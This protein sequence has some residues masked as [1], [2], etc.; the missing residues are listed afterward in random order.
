M[1]SELTQQQFNNL[2][3]KIQQNQIDPIGL[4]LYARAH[5][6]RQYKKVEEHWG[7]T[8]SEADIHL[9]VKVKIGSTGPM[10]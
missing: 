6:Y 9:T 5:E 7:E 4:G 1:I 3:K 10:K 2:I 8:L